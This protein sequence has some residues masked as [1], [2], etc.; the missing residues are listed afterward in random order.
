MIKQPTGIIQ[1]TNVAFIKYKINKMSF[2]IVCYKNKAIN[3]RNGVEKDISEVL[4]VDEI[5]TSASHG[6]IAKKADL[7]KYF[8]N[9]KK[10]EIIKLIL[11]K[12]ELQMGEKERAVQQ[13]NIYND[14]VNIITEKC[15]HP[16]SNR[17]FPVNQ[18]QQAMKSIN[19]VVKNDQPAKKQAL[20]CIKI[21]TK[22]Y[23]MKRADIL[24]SVS[25]P[26]EKHEELLQKLQAI[27]I[28]ETKIQKTI[29]TQNKIEISVII[30]SNKL[31]DILL[32]AKEQIEGCFVEEIDT[33]VKNDQTQQIENVQTVNL[34]LRQ[35]TEEEKKIDEK[36]D[37]SSE[38][39]HNEHKLKKKK[40]KKNPQIDLKAQQEK[41]KEFKNLQQKLEELNIVKDQ[42]QIEANIIHN[43][44]KDIKGS[45]KCTFC[46]DA[47]FYTNE[48][49]RQHFKTEW[50]LYNLKSKS[51]NEPPLSE[52]E[53]KVNQMDKNFQ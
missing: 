29:Q 26:K 30:E 35:N 38:S 31:R 20:E 42:Q 51:N 2:E 15:V 25:V 53:Y 3:W 44:Q 33:T 23:Y 14:I 24:V 21:L 4:Q 12:G 16:D 7:Q 18:I 49:Y 40:K 11:E 34:E 1:L 8:E 28:L 17:K 19:F 37:Q 47:Y 32:L 52:I 5:Y 6:T 48:E 43:E 10:M 41:E 39:E 50:H 9:M 22:K 13:S 46:K 36:E 27:N 45:K